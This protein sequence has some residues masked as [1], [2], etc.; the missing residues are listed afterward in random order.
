MVQAYTT[1]SSPKSIYSSIQLAGKTVSISCMHA[2]VGKGIL[3]C[4]CM[5]ANRG[6][7]MIDLVK[8]RSS[9]K[10]FIS[11]RLIYTSSV[12]FIQVEKR[13][14]NFRP[15][16]YI[17]TPVLQLKTKQLNAS[18]V[19]APQF[20]SLHSIAWRCLGTAELV[21]LIWIWVYMCPLPIT[22]ELTCLIL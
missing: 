12:G 11:R 18:T 22:D 13:I 2:W 19:K 17:V 16:N 15:S 4:W 21:R 7:H 8:H 9:I 1:A 6:R 5:P 3:G 14:E 10:S 20:W